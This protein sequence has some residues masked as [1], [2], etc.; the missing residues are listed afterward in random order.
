MNYTKKERELYNSERTKICD[1][2]GID[3]NSYNWLR[4]KGEEL[5]HL[6][7]ENCNGTIEEADYEKRTGELYEK[8]DRKAKELGLFIYYQ[9]DPRGATIYVDKQDIPEDNYT[10]AFCIW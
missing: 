10:R 8:A 1:K 2:L 9:T 7:E 4:R 6:Y 5:H 3:K